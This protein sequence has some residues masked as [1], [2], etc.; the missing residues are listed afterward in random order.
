M[1]QSTRVPSVAAIEV[2]AADADAAMLGLGASVDPSQGVLVLA[3]LEDPSDGEAPPML[4]SGLRCARQDIDA[5]GASLSDYLSL[6]RS[7][8]QPAVWRCAGDR[9][10]LSGAVEFDPTRVLRFARDARGE[11]VVIGVDFFGDAA[12]SSE[13]VDGLRAEIESAHRAPRAPCP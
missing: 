7:L 8:D 4:T 12:S 11:L 9:C 3:R 10:E 2:T 13:Y 1:A 5:L 6:R